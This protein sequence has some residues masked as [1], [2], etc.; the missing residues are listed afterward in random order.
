MPPLCILTIVVLIIIVIGGL[1]ST[2]GSVIAAV[3]FVLGGEALRAVEEPFALGPI[4]IPGVPGMRMVIFAVILI[5]VM[6]FARNGIMGRKEISWESLI[7][8]I[9][10]K[11]IGQG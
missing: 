5:A 10:R 8:R 1:G 11:R 9:Q 3:L 2:T 4:N 6:I 7:R